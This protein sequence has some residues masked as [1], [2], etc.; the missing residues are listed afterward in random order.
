MYHSRM[1][2]IGFHS[3]NHIQRNKKSVSIKHFEI[4]NHIFDGGEIDI[5]KVNTFFHDINNTIY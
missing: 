2:L 1:N 3:P 5:D 4:L